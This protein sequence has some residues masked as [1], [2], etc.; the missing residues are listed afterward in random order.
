MA[1]GMDLKRT[2]FLGSKNLGISWLILRNLRFNEENGIERGRGTGLKG[3]C[4]KGIE[5]GYMPVG[6]FHGSMS[7]R[8][9]H[10]GICVCLDAFFDGIVLKKGM[11]G[12]VGKR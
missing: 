8:H 11:M 2:V 5:S 4:W 9:F 6:V 3:S 7:F 12:R 1:F 10:V